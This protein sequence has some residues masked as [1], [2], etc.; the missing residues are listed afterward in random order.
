MQDGADP[1]GEG[2][3]RPLVIGDRDQRI[4]RP[5]PIDPGEV[6]QVQATVQGGQ[7]LVRQILE[8]REVDHVGVEVDDIEPVGL[9]PHGRQ[10]RHVGGEVGLQG[11]GI[12]P[13]GLITHHHQLRLGSGF[14]AGEQRHLVT[15]I[16]QGVRQVRHHALGAAI[17]P[18]RHSFVQGRNLGDLHGG[19]TSNGNWAPTGAASPF[20]TCGVA[21][22]FLLANKEPKRAS[23]VRLSRYSR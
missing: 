22:R 8:H 7:G 23:T 14:S 12:Q 16:D 1:V 10:H 13:N 4:L 9:T 17:E 19:R 20:E 15:K 5:L 11:R 3:G 18:R 6:F 21:L 2:Q